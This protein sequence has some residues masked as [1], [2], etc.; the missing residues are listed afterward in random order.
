MISARAIH[1]SH[2]S[3]VYRSISRATIALAYSLG[4]KVVAE[5][6]ENAQQLAFLDAEACDIAQGFLFS[7]PIPAAMIASLFLSR[8]ANTESSSDD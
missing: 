1:R 3:S 8:Q 6:V 2:I 5:G 7:K 4:M